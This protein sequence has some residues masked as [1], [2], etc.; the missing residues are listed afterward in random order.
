MIAIEGSLRAL[1]LGLPFIFMPMVA[2][3]AGCADP[4]TQT[5]MTICAGERFAKADTRLNKVWGDLRRARGTG[6]D[7]KE[8]FQVVLEAQRSW[9]VYRDAQCKAEGY[10]AHGG[11]MEPML[12]ADCK[13]RLTD[14][15]S[16]DLQDMLDQ[17]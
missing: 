15:R 17:R 3:Q 6:A 8:A 4:Q 1:A 10:A 2:A 12:V 13:A 9:L 16:K 14:E 7:E 11:T 5:E